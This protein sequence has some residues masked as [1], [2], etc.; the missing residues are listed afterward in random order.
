MVLEWRGCSL[1]INSTENW[2]AVIKVDIFKIDI[3][4]VWYHDSEVKEACRK[5]VSSIID[6]VNEVI[7]HT[8]KQLNILVVFVTEFS[9]LHN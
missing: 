2:W 4:N 9:Y 8:I 3:I 7:K 1:D 6:R 5:L